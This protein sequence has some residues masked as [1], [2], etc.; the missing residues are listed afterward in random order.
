MKEKEKLRKRESLA[1]AIG[2]PSEIIRG[3]LLERTIRHKKGCQT[4]ARGEGHPAL[5]LSINYPGGRNKQISIR[6][7]QREQVERWLKNYHNV[8]DKLEAICELNLTLLGPEKA[9]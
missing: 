2:H 4:C 3:S 8:K 5:I 7:E 9:E 1:R 6:P